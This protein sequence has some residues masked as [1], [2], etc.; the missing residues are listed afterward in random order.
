MGCLFNII[1]VMKNTGVKCGKPSMVGPIRQGFWR[2]HSQRHG[3]KLVPFA[4]G[5]DKCLWD[6]RRYRTVLR[7]PDYDELRP[8]LPAKPPQ[9]PKHPSLLIGCRAAREPGG[10]EAAGQLGRICPTRGK[11]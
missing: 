4:V 7:P 6:N 3:F 11:Q 2:N 1:H 8:T 5:Y 10:L 9:R